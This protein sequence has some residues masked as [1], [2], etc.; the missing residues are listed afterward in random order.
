MPSVSAELSKHIGQDLVYLTFKSAGLVKDGIKVHSCIDQ[1][2]PFP[3]GPAVSLPINIKYDSR[4]HACKLKPYF[5]PCVHFGKTHCLQPAVSAHHSTRLL[6][7]W[8]TLVASISTVCIPLP[9]Y[10]KAIRFSPLPHFILP[11]LYALYRGA[12]KSSLN[13]CSCFQAKIC[14][15]LHEAVL[16]S[17]VVTLQPVRHS[18]GVTG[19]TLTLSVAWELPWSWGS[20]ARPYAVLEY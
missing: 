5:P 9:S 20:F 7:V 18:S 1:I 13:I 11:W 2:V 16:S 15:C 17:S 4:C 3:W 12:K 6:G 8:C 14:I 10:R 19:I